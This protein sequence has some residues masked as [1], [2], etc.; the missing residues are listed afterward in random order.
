VI[1][2][3]VGGNHALW[4]DYIGVNRLPIDNT[5]L[6]RQ[7]AV[8]CSIASGTA[9][10]VGTTTVTCT[11]TDACGNSASTN[12]VVT[13]NDTEP[14]AVTC[15]ATVT[16]PNTPGLCSAVVT[17]NPVATDNCPGPVTVTTLPASGSVFPVGT[18]P[19]LVTAVDSH[20]NTNTCV[21]NVVVQDAE[22]P[23]VTCPAPVVKLVPQGYTSASVTFPPP[24]VSD[25]CGL[26]SYLVSPGSG[27][28][29]P[30]GTNTVQ[31]TAWD[32]GNNTNTCA[33]TVAV[34]PVN[35]APA[36]QVL[37]Y[38]NSTAVVEVTGVPGYPVVLEASTNLFDWT[39]IQTNLVPYLH[40]DSQSPGFSQRFYRAKFVP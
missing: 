32:A 39:A 24:A 10:P 3:V 22:A 2:S 38:T 16:Q 14:P 8:V 1:G 17:F 6:E 40:V 7:V 25:N 23:S 18:T 13:V 36:V 27:S 35:P 15:P 30:I 26:F 9:F 21:F 11:A 20:N 29:F 4:F 33:F 37:T 28:V 5:L 19:V 31:V 12:F 34:V